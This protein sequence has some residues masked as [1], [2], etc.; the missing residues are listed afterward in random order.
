VISP[1]FHTAP[2]PWSASWAGLVSGPVSWA[3]NTQINYALVNWEC[4]RGKNPLAV[5]AAVLTLV[6]LAGALSSWL[7]WRRYDPSRFT[8]PQQDGHPHRL[9]SAIGVTF[10]IL[11][12]IVIVMQSTAGIFLEP[13][14]R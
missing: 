6:S 7:A 11:F 1:R 9:L 8:V 10:G 13:C 12:A 14:L 4:S 2:W 3:L 5:I